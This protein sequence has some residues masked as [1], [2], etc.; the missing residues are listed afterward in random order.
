MC[1]GC[2]YFVQFKNKILRKFSK[3]SRRNAF[4]CVPVPSSYIFPHSSPYR[5][6]CVYLWIDIFVYLWSSPFQPISPSALSP[7]RLHLPANAHLTAGN[8]SRNGCRQFLFLAHPK[9]V[10][11]PAIRLAHMLSKILKTFRFWSVFCFLFCC[12]SEFH[13]FFGVCFVQ[14]C[15]N[16]FQNTHANSR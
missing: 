12:F 14:R 16:Y 2:F 4:R 13:I 7:R 10:S 1:F 6:T 15:F 5:Y 11:M 8:G 3:K 9:S